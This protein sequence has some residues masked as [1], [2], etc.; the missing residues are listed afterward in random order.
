MKTNAPD[1]GPFFDRETAGLLKGAALILMF[2]HHFFTFPAWI[3]ADAGYPLIS[4]AAPFLSRSTRICA[5]AFAFLTGC[6]AC[7]Q[8]KRGA[9]E[10]ISLLGP[11]HRTGGPRSPGDSSGALRAH[12]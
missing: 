12:P 11:V 9:R 1:C 8:P 4:A 2:F 3:V 6:A 7:W 5:P 10:G